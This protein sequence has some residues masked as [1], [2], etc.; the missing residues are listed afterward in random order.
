ML[1]YKKGILL[2]GISLM[3]WCNSFAQVHSYE[4]EQLDSLQQVES[5]NVIVFLH[6]DWCQYCKAMQNTTFKNENIIRSLNTKFYFI[7][8]DG[9]EKRKVTFK[10]HVF[11][12][13]PTGN[14]VGSHELA[15][16]LASKNGQVTYPTICILNHD[17]EIIFQNSGFL[18]AKE[19]KGILD[20]L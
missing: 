20:K 19:L 10:G 12:Y 9:E 2:F 4:F 16:E 18:N 17:N 6:T 13:R 15:L 7:K 11:Q 14:G 8:F 3:I 5:K 1:L